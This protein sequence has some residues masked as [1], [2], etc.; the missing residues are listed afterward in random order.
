LRFSK[1]S[2]FGAFNQKFKTQVQ[3][4]CH[5]FATRDEIAAFVAGFS[6]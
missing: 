4:F 1:T 6:F 2:K 5:Y 3:H